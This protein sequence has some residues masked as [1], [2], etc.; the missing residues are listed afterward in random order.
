MERLLRMEKPRERGS[1]S[2]PVAGSPAHQISCVTRANFSLIPPPMAALPAV[3]FPKNKTALNKAIKI[4][5]YNFILNS[6]PNDAKL[7]WG[8]GEEGKE[9]IC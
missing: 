3:T 9:A 7:G 8:G 4:F 1:G 2:I 6:F 5:Q